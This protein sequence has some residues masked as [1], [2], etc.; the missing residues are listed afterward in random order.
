ML[1]SIQSLILVAEPYFNEPGYERSRNTPAGQQSSN[2][3]SANIKQATVKWAMLNQLK[4]PCPSFKDVIQ[5]HFYLKKEK[6]LKQVNSWLALMELMDKNKR[7]GKKLSNHVASLKKSYTAL[8]EELNKLEAPDSID[9]ETKNAIL[10][11]NASS[12]QVSFSDANTVFEST[13]GQPGSSLPT[14]Y[15]KSLFDDPKSGIAGSEGKCSTSAT[16]S[17][18]NPG[19]LMCGP[20]GISEIEVLEEL[21]ECPQSPDQ[22]DSPTSKAATDLLNSVLDVV[23]WSPAVSSSITG[24]PADL[25]NVSSTSIAAPEEE[26]VASQSFM[27]F[28]PSVEATVELSTSHMSVDETHDNTEISEEVSTNQNEA[29]MV[30]S[31]NNQDA[32]Y[33]TQGPMDEGKNKTG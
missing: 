21:K 10:R 4:N 2:E 16:V 5:A 19:S 17:D 29:I 20:N 3:Y 22:T 28:Q 31:S 14:N 32:S 12:K 13:N 15:V 9:E 11:T 25:E 18:F 1:V 7:Y 24:A 27:E 33:V 6:I 30:E 23:F 8:A 26:V